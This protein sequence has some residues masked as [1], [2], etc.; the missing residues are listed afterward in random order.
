MKL[1]QAVFTVL[2]VLASQNLLAMENKRISSV[3]SLTSCASLRPFQLSENI[4]EKGF[5]PDSFFQLGNDKELKIRINR[6]RKFTNKREIE[7]EI[8]PIKLSA[9]LI[10]KMKIGFQPDLS[11]A[12]WEPFKYNKFVDIPDSE[13]ELVVY[14]SLQ[15]KAGNISPVEKAKIIVDTS[16]PAGASVII[17]KGAKVTNDPGMRVR[18]SIHA[19]DAYKM[20]ISNTGQF[21]YS[22]WEDYVPEKN[23]MIG[24]KKEEKKTVYVRFADKATNISEPIQASILV[25]LTPPDGTIEINQGAKFTHTRKVSV[26]IYSKDAAVVR[27]VGA[28]IKNAPYQKT[29]E[30]GSMVRT[31]ELDS[32]DGRKFIKVFF[33]D[34]AGNI[35]QKPAIDEIVLDT[36]APEIGLF[37]INQGQK[38]ATHPD[39]RVTLKIGTREDLTSFDMYVSNDKTFADAKPRAYAPKIDNWQLDATEDGLK[40]VYLKFVDKAGNVS[41]TAIAKVILDR[42]PPV[43]K[44]IV[45][46]NGSDWVNKNYVNLTIDGTGAD[47]MEVSNSPKFSQVNAWEVFGKSRGH[48]VLPVRDGKISVYAR[49]K[50]KAGNVSETISDFINKDTKSPTGKIS[51]NNG[52]R[53]T[54]DLSKAVKVSL[55]YDSDAYEMQVNDNPNFNN[56]K[57]EMVS[58]S[59]NNWVL[60]GEDGE[61]KIFARYKDK[62]GN[63]SEI[64]AARIILDTQPPLYPSISING[65]SLYTSRMDKMVNLEINAEDAAY[66]M[67]SSNPD[68]SDAKWEKYN[69]QRKFMLPGQDGEKEIFVKFQDEAGNT[70]PASS[71]K[72]ILDRYPPRPVSFKINNGE[73]WTNHA[74]KEVTLKIQAEGATQMIIADNPEFTG[75]TWQEY[76]S[77]L[78]GFKLPGDDGVKTLFITFKDEAG[79]KSKSLSATIKLKREF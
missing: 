32:L 49:F 34:N 10:S 40:S 23:W 50:D 67:I 64:M 28:G 33:R 18:L 79:H 47:Y 19:M 51:I 25:D 57:W 62:A 76:K 7:V 6:G 16:P 48:W 77:E 70:S 38:Y 27:I 56:V 14:A 54:N 17:N 45:I 15:D 75:A 21:N 13:G 46:D 68:F 52:A 58:A 3:K 59:I 36:K 66:M 37:R 5:H 11:D 74:N 1:T 53:F 78:P 42:Q 29:E 8:R 44:E 55:K 4:F 72:I 20:Q 61:K 22:D 60:D 63:I 30:D 12:E 9:T 41:K 43:A 2:M 71:D 73:E 35:N 31:V 65:D 39:G 24:P 69:Q 26:K